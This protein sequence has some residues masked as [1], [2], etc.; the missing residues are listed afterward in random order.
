MADNH[1]VV[2]AVKAEYRRYHA[3]VHR[4]G[5]GS[6]GYFDVD[7]EVIDLD[8]GE[9]GMLVC[10]EVGHDGVSAGDGEEQLALV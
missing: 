7:A 9:L 2:I 3:F 6:G 10:T 8:L 1:D 4:A 5:L